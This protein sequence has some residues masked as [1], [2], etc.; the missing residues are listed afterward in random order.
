MKIDRFEL[1]L[2]DSDEETRVIDIIYDAL[3]EI[4]K[5]KRSFILRDKKFDATGDISR[6]KNGYVLDCHR[7]MKDLAWVTKRYN[8]EYSF[9]LNKLY[10]FVFTS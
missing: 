8:A 7:S 1:H 4:T 10:S 9:A 3:N 2:G 6:L 5:S